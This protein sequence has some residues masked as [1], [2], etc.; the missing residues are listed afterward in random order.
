MPVSSIVFVRTWQKAGSV[1][2]VARRLGVTEHAAEARAYRYRKLGVPLKHFRRPQK[3]L[4]I[5]ALWRAARR[6]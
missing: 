3:H 4:D 6:G 2:A 5:I 1:A